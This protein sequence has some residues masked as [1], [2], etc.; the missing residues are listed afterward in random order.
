MT[1]IAE[2][3]AG[4][5]VAPA[6]RR[7]VVRRHPWRRLAIAAAGA[8]VAGLFVGFVG[9]ARSLVDTPPPPDPRA[10]GIVV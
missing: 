6:G 4:L 2:D 3:R 8:G 9:F 1:E 10:E 5:D 7:R